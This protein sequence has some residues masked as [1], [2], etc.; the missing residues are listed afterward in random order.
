MTTKTSCFSIMAGQV[1][2]TLALLGASACSDKSDKSSQDTSSDRIENTGAAC[3]IPSDCYPNVDV[4]TIQ[5]EVRCLDRV[6]DGYCTHLCETDDDCC[7][8]D[9]ECTEN[10]RQVCSPFEST[11]LTMCF[12][13]CEK[14]DLVAPED[15][16]AS[17][18]IDDNEYCQREAGAE[19]ICRSSGGGSENRK[20]CVP[21]DCGGVGSSCGADGDCEDGLTCLADFDGG[22]CGLLGCSANEDCP[23]GTACVQHPNGNNYC[24]LI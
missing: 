11:D 22:Y 24:Y 6:H 15:A 18:P 12:L 13:S 9:G 17:D 20:V 14:S 3:Q 1:V 7:A 16:P 2:C 19:F 23:D 10:I 4:A 5:G 8:A 21:G